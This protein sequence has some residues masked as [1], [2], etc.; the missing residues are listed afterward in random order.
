MRS[1]HTY[2]LVNRRERH[3]RSGQRTLQTRLS[4]IGL[5]LGALLGLLLVIA[6]L[7]LVLTY[8]DVT[9]D[10]PSPASLPAL[11]DPPDGLLL[12]PTLLYDRSG[13]HLI[14]TLENPGI[15]RR[16]ISLDPKQ[17]EHLPQDLATVILATADPGFWGHPGFNLSELTPGQIFSAST[18]NTLAERLVSDLLLANEATGWRRT[19]RQDLLAAQLTNQYGRQRILEWYLNNVYYGHMAYGA[20]AASQLYLGKPASA[21]N[22]S[23]SALLASVAMAPALNPL[24][25]PEAARSGQQTVLKL[26]LSK[27]IYSQDQINQALQTSL[28]FRQAAQTDQG[29]GKTPALAFS[30]EVIKTLSA[31]LGQERVER[32]GLIVTTT[33][34]YELQQQVECAAGFL[35]AS[36]ASAGDGSGS[37]SPL[38]TSTCPAARLMPTQFLSQPASSSDLAVSAVVLDPSNGQVLALSGDTTS[39]MGETDFGLHPSGTLLTPFIYLAGFTHGDSPASLVWDIPASLPPT[40]TGNSNPDGKFHGPVRMRLALANDYLAPSAQLLAQIG[41]ENV[42]GQAQPFGLP[43]MVGEAL[44]YSGGQVTPLQAAQAFGVFANG[45]ILSSSQTILKVA[46]QNDFSSQAAGPVLPQPQSRPILSATLTYLMNQVLS[47]ESARWPSLGYSNPLEIGRPAGAKLGQTADG[48]ST[49]AVGYTPKRVVAV[50]V[51]S[52]LLLPGAV[53]NQNVGSGSG[54][55]TG[56]PR[57]DPRLPASLWHALIQYASQ[58]L[59]PEGWSMPTGITQ[60]QVCDPSG[61][62]PTQACP[63]Q[64]SEVFLTDN[65]PTSSDNLYQTFQINRETGRLATVFT[66]AD[67][68]EDK[69]FL[70]VPP[71]A[72][73]WAESTGLPVPPSLYDAIQAPVEQPDIHITSPIF[74]GSIRGQI[75]IQG[76]AAGSDFSSYQVQVGEGINPQ[77]WIQI[78]EQSASPVTEDTLAAWDTRK[79]EDGLYAIRVQVVHKDQQVTSAVIQVTVD[80]TAPVV[81]V[82]Y[83]SQKQTIQYSADLNLVLQAQA[84]DAVGLDRVEFWIDDRLVGSLSQVPFNLS[85]QGQLGQHQLVIKAYDRAGNQ[86]ASVP[87]LFNIVK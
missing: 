56:R 76:T 37:G 34:D 62:I 5:A 85:W 73:T 44:P 63:N 68:I 9:R 3:R 11:L 7:L 29:K 79:Q 83:P 17:P 20:E 15:N 14:M 1:L 67:K 72:R 81:S 13:S 42:W 80:N 8:A 82:I 24:D 16:I 50:W 26:L 71:E 70:V 69:T 45:G 39:Q 74:F 43:S 75:K 41:P 78:G 36:V 2:L 38:D 31:E 30:D 53:S 21:L 65:V 66:P 35:L 27:G 87:V 25:A 18:P 4:R 58:Q 10:L 23:E 49:W 52:R 6:S 32:G 86:G 22:L 60:A 77:N 12:H 55:T 46:G 48:Q 28:V 84:S 59:A 61:M 57:I 51:G 19:L 54:D 40:A 33:L 47:D 64:V